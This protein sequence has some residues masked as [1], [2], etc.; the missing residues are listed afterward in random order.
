MIQPMAKKK[1]SSAD[2]NG[3][4]SNGKETTEN[5]LAVIPVEFVTRTE[6][7]ASVSQFVVQFAQGEFHVRMFQIDPPILLGN[8]EERAATAKS[9][10]RVVANEKSHSVISA[11]NMAKLLRILVQNYRNNVG[12]IDLTVSEE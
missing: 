5:P 8:K 11:E 9:I 1:A 4:S 6:N 2:S 3:A 7:M 10:D 12:E